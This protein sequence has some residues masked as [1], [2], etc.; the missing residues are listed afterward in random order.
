LIKTVKLVSVATWIN[1]KNPFWPVSIFIFRLQAVSLTSF[2]SVLTFFNQK[3]FYLFLPCAKSFQFVPLCLCSL[4][5]ENLRENQDFSRSASCHSDFSF[6]SILSESPSLCKL[7][8]FYF[9]LSFF[10]I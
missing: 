8:P 4:C 5:N 10:F 1:I 7:A 9:I 6:N 2:Y 3:S